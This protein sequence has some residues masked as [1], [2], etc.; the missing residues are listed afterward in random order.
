MCALLYYISD[1][2]FLY[3][4]VKRK[5]HASKLLFHNDIAGDIN[6]KY[7]ANNSH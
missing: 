7:I 6:T 2:L 5:K 1:F 3:I 4:N